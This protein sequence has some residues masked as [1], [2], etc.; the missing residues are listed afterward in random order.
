[1]FCYFIIGVSNGLWK[2]V[3]LVLEASFMVIEVVV[4]VIFVVMVVDCNMVVGLVGDT[5]FV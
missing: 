5:S 4:V 2:V 3:G 1:M